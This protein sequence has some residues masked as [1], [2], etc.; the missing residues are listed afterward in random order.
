MKKLIF[1]DVDGVLNNEEVFRNRP[2]KYTDPGIIFDD[3]CVKRLNR[4]IKE[5]DAKLVLSST[6]RLYKGHRD[7]LYDVNYSGIKGEFI[8]ETPDLIYDISRET[9]RGMEIEEWLNNHWDGGTC[10]FIILDDD[11]DMDPYMNH[12]IQTRFEVGL[13]D[14]IVEK[15]INALNKGG[16]SYEK[17][18][19]F[20]EEK[21]M[22]DV[23]T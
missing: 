19:N 3:E 7:A 20:P 22:P 21:R 15:A 23:Q 4:I 14:E 6:W 17:T 16:G 1:L 5:T 12:L 13:T 10:R 9:C 18:F 8:G 2:S 11:N